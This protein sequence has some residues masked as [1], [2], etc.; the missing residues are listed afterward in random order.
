MMA[1]V[2]VRWNGVG[3]RGSVAQAN[4]GGPRYF[5]DVSPTVSAFLNAL[6][7]QTATAPVLL[8]LVV[9]WTAGLKKEEQV[10]SLKSQ[11][12]QLLRVET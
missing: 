7:E 10:S 6:P 3:R 8:T 5:Y 11:V 1:A 12:S 9:N 4:A 2:K